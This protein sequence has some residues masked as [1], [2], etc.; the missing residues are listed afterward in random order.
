MIKAEIVELSGSALNRDV[1]GA[2]I[3]TPGLLTAVE[4]EGYAPLQAAEAITNTLLDKTRAIFSQMLRFDQ[5]EVKNGAGKI[6]SA[7]NLTLTNMQKEIPYLVA[8]FYSLCV[9][10][11]ETGQGC[12][13]C[14]G[15]SGIMLHAG[16]WILLGQE[17]NDNILT[18]ALGHSSKPKLYP[19]TV[20]SDGLLLLSSGIIKRKDSEWRNAIESA[21]SS[22]TRLMLLRDSIKSETAEVII[23]IAGGGEHGN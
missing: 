17:G 18:E 9:V 10:D 21:Q 12:V 15:E 22:E 4:A 8:G 19:I 2:L 16:R 14:T 7:V 6:I 5:D 23:S 13:I 3:E 20:D 1:K 11:R